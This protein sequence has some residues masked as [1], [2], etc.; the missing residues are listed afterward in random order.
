MLYAV[1]G[2]HDS[3][4]RLKTVECFNV[5][6]QEWEYCPEMREARG[7][8]RFYPKAPARGETH[9]NSVQDVALAHTRSITYLISIIARCT[10]LCLFSRGETLWAS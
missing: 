5:Q 4:Y 6:T 1:G 10:E 9:F 8:L 3:G 2:R 7:A